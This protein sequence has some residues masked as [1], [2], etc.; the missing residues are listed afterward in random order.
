MNTPISPVSQ[1]E[2]DLWAAVGR[3]GR[4]GYGL[5][6]ADFADR[7]DDKVHVSDA[8]LDDFLSGNTIPE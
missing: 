6:S 4:M 7:D 1:R 3:K 8:A 2:R 5:I